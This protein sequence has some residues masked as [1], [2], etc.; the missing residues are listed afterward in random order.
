MVGVVARNVE[1]SIDGCI[2]IEGLGCELGYGGEC[3]SYL[4]QVDASLLNTVDLTYYETLCRTCW[5]FESEE[6]CAS[7]AEC[8]WDGAGC[9]YPKKDLQGVSLTS[10]EYHP[11]LIYNEIQ[12]HAVCSRI[13]EEEICLQTQSC[14]WSSDKM[15]IRDIWKVMQDCCEPLQPITD[16]AEQCRNRSNSEVYCLTLS[17]TSTTTIL[18]G[19]TTSLPDGVGTNTTFSTTKG[20]QLITV[21][22]E[23]SNTSQLSGPSTATT[24]APT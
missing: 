10:E 19:L 4:A 7:M 23:S 22:A 18:E 2:W 24:V 1:A 9:M 20:V 8:A 14:L 13:K 17:E 11:S 5:W 3:S 6:A 15:C 12:S 21:R 16:R